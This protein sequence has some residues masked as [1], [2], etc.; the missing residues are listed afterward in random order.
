MHKCV[1]CG[2]D[3]IL[4][5]NGI[6]ICVECD[7]EREKKTPQYHLLAKTQDAIVPRGSVR[8]YRRDGRYLLK[9]GVS[10]R[11]SAPWIPTS[12]Y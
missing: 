12:G 8:L 5:I 1:L 9:S 4:F 2:A 7:E 6:P 11:L 3:T 10:H